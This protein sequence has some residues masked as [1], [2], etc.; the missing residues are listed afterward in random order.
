MRSPRSGNHRPRNGAQLLASGEV[1]RE[2]LYAAA[3]VLAR[4]QD[5]G[6]ARNLT[7]ADMC[8]ILGYLR[9]AETTETAAVAS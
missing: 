6:V 1:D 4:L 2:Q 7:L 5:R 9:T 8:E 3:V